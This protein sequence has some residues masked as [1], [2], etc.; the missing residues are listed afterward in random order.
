MKI[1]VS[2]IQPW[3]CGENNVIVKSYPAQILDVCDQV[4]TY[5]PR[6]QRIEVGLCDH[7]VI[8]VSRHHLFYA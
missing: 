5:I 2:S 4:L 6:F 3:F 1:A 7:H 8:C